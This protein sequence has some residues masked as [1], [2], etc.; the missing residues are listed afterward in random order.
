MECVLKQVF[1]EH[2]RLLHVRVGMTPSGRLKRALGLV[3]ASR[4][5]ELGMSQQAL[6]LRAGVATPYLGYLERG[7]TGLV[8]LDML[9]AVGE[10]LDVLPE[11]LI[12]EARARLDEVSETGE[13]ERPT[14]RKGRPVGSKRATK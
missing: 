4:R 9:T 14:V 5:V 11:A 12:A 1:W 10:V 7:E 8:T 3:I 13:V 6:A 2:S